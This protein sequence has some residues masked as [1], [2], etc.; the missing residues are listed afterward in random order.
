MICREEPLKYH[1]YPLP[2]VIDAMNAHC[3]KY[4][5]GKI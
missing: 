1:Y 3:N 2:T 4:K 5:R